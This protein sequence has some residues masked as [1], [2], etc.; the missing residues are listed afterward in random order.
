VNFLFRVD[1]FEEIGCGHLIRCLSLAHELLNQQHKVFFIGYYPLEQYRQLILHKNIVIEPISCISEKEDATKTLSTAK[2]IQANMVIVDSYKLSHHWQEL[3]NDQVPLCVFDD[4]PNRQHHCQLLIDPTI[5]RQANEYRP[6]VGSQCQLL[7]GEKYTLLRDSFSKL[8]LKNNTPSKITAQ[9][10]KVLIFFGATDPS[11]VTFDVLCKMPKDI[12]VIVLLN[13]TSPAYSKVVTF[14]GTQT[15]IALLTYCQ[16][17]ADLMN[18]VDLV[19]GA[20]GSNSWERCCLGIPSLTL[21]LADNQLDIATVMTKYHAA[22]NFGSPTK[23]N[24]NNLINQLFFLQNNLTELKAMSENAKK[25]CDGNGAN[26]VSKKML[27]YL[28]NS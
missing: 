26:R 15:N 21:T 18:S 16:K 13:E 25:L 11:G 27:T 23:V 22:H 3:F 6:L 7:L 5:N 9:L 20:P 19:I 8:R 28:N 10:N 14:I 2:N 1:A 17:M 24:I 4:I 12:K